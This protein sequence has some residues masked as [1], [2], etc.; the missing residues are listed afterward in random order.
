MMFRKSDYFILLAVMISFVRLRL[1]LV[2]GAGP[3]AGDIHRHLDPIHIRL[4]HLLQARRS[5]REE[6]VNANELL[7]LGVV[8]F[9]ILVVGLVSTIQE[10]RKMN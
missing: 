7:V 8:V 9:G 4:W 5:A 10:F 1:P 2:C 6:K 3:R